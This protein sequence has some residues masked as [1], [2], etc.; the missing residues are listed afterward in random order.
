LLLYLEVRKKRRTGKK[1]MVRNQFKLSQINKR[2]RIAKKMYDDAH[3]KY[4][5]YKFT[6]SG[7]SQEGLPTNFLLDTKKRFTRYFVKHSI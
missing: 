5:G 1:Y 3:R 2:F 6:L 7:H 4:K